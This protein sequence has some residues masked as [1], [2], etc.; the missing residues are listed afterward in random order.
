M[1]PII[2]KYGMIEHSGVFGKSGARV[3]LCFGERVLPISKRVIGI[4]PAISSPV[5]K[6]IGIEQRLRI[7]SIPVVFRRIRR[8]NFEMFNNESGIGIYGFIETPLD[9]AG[10]F[11]NQGEPASRRDCGGI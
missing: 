7:G 8:P 4:K 3:S 2:K 5:R 9:G 6:G 10:Q 11:S 1:V